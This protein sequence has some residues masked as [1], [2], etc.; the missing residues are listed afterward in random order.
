MINVNKVIV[1]GNLGFDPELRKAGETDV[2]N[3]SVATSFHKGKGEQREEI[4]E[5]HR[6]VLFDQNA[7][8]ASGFLHKGDNVYVEG[9][10]Q[11]RKWTDDKGEHSVT[12]IVADVFQGTPRSRSEAPSDDTSSSA[13]KSRGRRQ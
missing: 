7:H 13:G 3:V 9:R 1:A 2:C 8:Y 11:T 5:W 10:L 4:T 12:E 6:V